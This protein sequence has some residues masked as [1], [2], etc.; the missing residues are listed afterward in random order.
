MQTW[1]EENEEKVAQVWVQEGGSWPGGGV[2]GDGEAAGGETRG[3]EMLLS[4]QNYLSPS[5]G[6]G[7][8]SGE[9]EDV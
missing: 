7:L 1:D 8:S 9:E 6:C 5:G 4:A 2:C 3:Q